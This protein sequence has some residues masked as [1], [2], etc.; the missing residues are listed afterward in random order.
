M[1]VL[2]DNSKVQVITK[3]VSKPRPQKEKS[4]PQLKHSRMA[5]GFDWKTEQVQATW[6]RRR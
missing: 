2:S 5:R 6:K 3:L 4:K 1:T